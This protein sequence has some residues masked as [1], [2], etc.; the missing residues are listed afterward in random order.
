MHLRI[1]L[2][3]DKPESKSAA[4]DFAH[5]RFCMSF[6]Y[7]SVFMLYIVVSLHFDV[8]SSAHFLHSPAFVFLYMERILCYSIII[9][10]MDRSDGRL[11]NAVLSIEPVSK[12]SIS[13]SA[14]ILPVSTLYNRIQKMI[15]LSR[16]YNR[17]QKMILLS[18]LYN[19]IQ[20]M[21]L[22]SRLHNG[23]QD[24]IL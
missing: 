17:I 16:L 24:R 2:S 22:L 7:Q 13:F 21:I 20:K 4:C 1:Y 6:Y 18:R 11:A 12:V 9:H 15:L 8:F 14:F 10:D 19:G 3:P 5:T 23:I